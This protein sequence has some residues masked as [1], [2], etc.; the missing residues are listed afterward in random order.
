[1]SVMGELLDGRKLFGGSK[2]KHISR[3]KKR[4]LWMRSC[5]KPDTVSG[6]LRK[7]RR[8]GEKGEGGQ[9]AGSARVRK[10]T[11]GRRRPL[12]ICPN[13]GPGC[14]PGTRKLYAISGGGGGAERSHQASPTPPGGGGVQPSSWPG[15]RERCD[16]QGKYVMM[17]GG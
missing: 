7:R 4:G 14:R 16:I 1:M 8:V 3:N 6:E 10:M 13:T 2:G 17:G 12:T 5:E 15:T 11:R 9:G